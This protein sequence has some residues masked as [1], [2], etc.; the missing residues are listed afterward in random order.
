MLLV[1]CR[2]SRGLIAGNVGDTAWFLL[3]SRVESQEASSVP[4]VGLLAGKEDVAMAM[5]MD[6]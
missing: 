3:G 5:A 2:Q 6:R 1:H 4:K